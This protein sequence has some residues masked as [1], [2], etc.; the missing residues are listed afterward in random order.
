MTLLAASAP[1]ALISQSLDLNTAPITGT[2]QG[3]SRFLKTRFT[4][5]A[6]IPEGMHSRTRSGLSV[7]CSDGDLKGRLRSAAGPE[8]GSCV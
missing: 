8:P 2:L 6:A 1:C 5:L 7:F 4:Y 3:N